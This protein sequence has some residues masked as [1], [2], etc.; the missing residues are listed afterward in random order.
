M[1]Y[2]ASSHCLLLASPYFR[3]LLKGIQE[4]E[5]STN[6]AGLGFCSEMSEKWDPA[7]LLTILQIIH[8]QFDKVPAMLPNEDFLGKV[9]VIVDH[10]QCFVTL[11]PFTETWLSKSEEPLKRS[12]WFSSTA[13]RLS[14]YL[15]TV[16][17]V[18]KASIWACLLEA[19]RRRTFRKGYQI[20]RL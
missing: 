4:N 19:S 20:S 14:N 18:R 15:E 10:L 9:C 1:V 12:K 16:T 17:N 11:K 7:A 13:T 6:H 5:D 3:R 8:V 2:R